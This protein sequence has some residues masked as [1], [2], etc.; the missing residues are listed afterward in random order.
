MTVGEKMHQ[1]LAGLESAKASIETF[2]LDTQDQ[3]AKQEFFQYSSQLETICNGLTGRV[4]YIEQQ[5]PQYKIKDQARHQAQQ[6]MKK[7]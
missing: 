7:Q 4:N 3:M 6:Q 5:E 1:A 2:A